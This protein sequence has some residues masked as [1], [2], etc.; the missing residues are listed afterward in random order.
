[1]VTIPNL[2]NIDLLFISEFETYYNLWI[3]QQKELYQPI[4]GVSVIFEFIV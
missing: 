4:K 2:N 1:M 3:S